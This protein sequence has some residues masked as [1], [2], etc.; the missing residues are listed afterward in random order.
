VVRQAQRSSREVARSEQ[1]LRTV[2]GASNDGIWDWHLESGVITWSDR[3]YEILR[4]NR[5]GSAITIERLRELVHPDDRELFSSALDSHLNHQKPFNLE[6]RILR[7]DGSY[8]HFLGRGSAIRSADGTPLRMVGSVSDITERRQLDDTLKAN[9]ALLQQFVKHTP[10][11]VAMFDTQMRYIQVSDRWLK[12]YR[13]ESTQLV[14]RPYY[15]VF[16]NLPDRWKQIHQR[17]LRGAIERSDE[18]SF[19]RDDGT[20]EWL[21]WEIQPWR[22]AHGQ[23]GGL[24]MF[25]LLVNE[26]KRDEQKILEQ[27]TELQRWQRVTLGREERTLQLKSEVNELCRRLNE[28]PR[29]GTQVAARDQ[30]LT[31]A[32]PK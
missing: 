12:D 7:G 16:P 26:R 30:T 9:E 32:V 31:A 29:Y 24:I 21:Q 4:M 6:N 2:I 28:G 20:S 27:L 15:D 25:T 22:D 5:D 10:A 11:A 19:T 23:I 3:V 14:G 18:D 8:G 17:V 13:L 1:L